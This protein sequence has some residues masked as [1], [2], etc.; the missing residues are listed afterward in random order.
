[1]TPT[2]NRIEM[3]RLVFAFALVLARVK[4]ILEIVA[5]FTAKEN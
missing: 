5:I 3:V 2:L 4:E 1:M